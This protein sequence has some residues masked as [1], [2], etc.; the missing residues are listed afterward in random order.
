MRVVRVQRE[1]VRTVRRHLGESRRA[2]EGGHIF[3]CKCWTSA[4][5][6][7]ILQCM[8]RLLRPLKERRRERELARELE[9]RFR[10]QVDAAAAAAARLADDVDG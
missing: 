5:S 7:C 6:W 2:A 10:G 4:G 8:R 9:R 3:T 1:P